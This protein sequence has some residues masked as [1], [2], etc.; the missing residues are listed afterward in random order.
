MNL[1]EIDYKVLK[2]MKDEK[3]S[4]ET[5]ELK[6]FIYDNDPKIDFENTLKHLTGKGFIVMRK[7]QGFYAITIAGQIAT[8]EYEIELRSKLSL[9]EETN[10]ISI[11]ANRIANKANQ[12]S[13]KAIKDSRFANRLSIISII[14]VIIDILL[15]VFKV[16]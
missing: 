14:L 6:K 7:R 16:I 9:P 4:F 10:K 3:H 11:E 1:R 15:R 13:L 12:L 8:E 2:L 5:L